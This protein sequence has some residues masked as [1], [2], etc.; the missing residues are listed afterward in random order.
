MGSYGLNRKGSTIDS[1]LATSQVHPNCAKDR[2]V[3]ETRIGYQE[4]L[5]QLR[6]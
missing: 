6:R 1:R 5:R 2:T 3:A 4:T